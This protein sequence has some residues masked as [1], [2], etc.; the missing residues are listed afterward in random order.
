MT[1]EEIMKAVNKTGSKGL[2][3][4]CISI[5]IIKL[6]SS[7]TSGELVKI[8]EEAGVN[9]EEIDISWRYKNELQELEEI[10]DESTSR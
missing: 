7:V 9:M 4:D 1:D 2:A 5:W 3:W 8:V 10:D 6:I